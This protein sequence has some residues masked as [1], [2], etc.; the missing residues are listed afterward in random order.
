MGLV[1]LTSMSIAADPANSVCPPV[2]G[3]RDLMLTSVS[4]VGFKKRMGEFC[5]VPGL[6][7]QSKTAEALKVLGPCLQELGVKQGEIQAALNKGEAEAQEVYE[8]SGVKP[9]LCEDARAA[10]E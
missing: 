4:A 10:F 6:T 3:E 2:L 9:A 1:A 7:I 5:A 8:H